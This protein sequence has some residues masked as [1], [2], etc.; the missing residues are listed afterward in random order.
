[1]YSPQDDLV[2][3]CCV[4]KLSFLVALRERGKHNRRDHFF[5]GLPWKTLPQLFGNE[6]HER[7]KEAK[8]DIKARVERIQ[9]ALL[10]HRTTVS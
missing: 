2:L 3:F 7:M 6:W 1:M 4:R 9:N 10:F 5:V 8:G